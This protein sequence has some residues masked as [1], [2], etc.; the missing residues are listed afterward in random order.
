MTQAI[1]VANSA[2]EPAANT[3]TTMEAHSRPNSR[4]RN[5]GLNWAPSALPM[6]TCAAMRM[7][8]GMRP[9]SQP[10]LLTSAAMKSGTISQ[11]LGERVRE[12]SVATRPEPASN[13]STARP[14]DERRRQERAAAASEEREHQEWREHHDER[15][16]RG[17]G[18]H[19][20]LEPP[21]IL[22]SEVRGLDD[23][24]GNGGKERSGAV[25]PG[26]P[27]ID[28]AA[29]GTDDGGE[30]RSRKNQR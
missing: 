21:A 17:L 3:T 15:D 18:D 27:H 14:W 8:S 19:D 7:R 4:V 28:E 2:I 20:G 16:P 29:D 13:A 9:S 26:E 6:T 12:R 11:A 10:R 25:D 30:K 24:S 5:S 23:T 22:R 1:A